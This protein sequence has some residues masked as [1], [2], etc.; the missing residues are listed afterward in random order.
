MS[1]SEKRASPE[2]IHLRLPVGL[3][4]IVRYEAESMELTDASFVRHI[5]AMTY[6]EVDPADVL[7]TK[8]RR[9]QNAMPSMELIEISAL[10]E[11]VAEMGGTLRQV[12]GLSR[13]SGRTANHQAIEEML[14]L[15]KGYLAVLDDLKK[16]MT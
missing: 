7:P 13:R 12:A 8:R 3:A 2:Q 10:R 5:L 1:T 6:H 11:S 16:V 14:P 4:R 15:I 9:K